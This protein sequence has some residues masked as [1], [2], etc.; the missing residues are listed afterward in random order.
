MNEYSFIL[1]WQKNLVNDQV[2]PEHNQIFCVGLL[3]FK[4]VS[5][6]LHVDAEIQIR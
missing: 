1:R 6:H 2:I 3:S 4:S 5:L